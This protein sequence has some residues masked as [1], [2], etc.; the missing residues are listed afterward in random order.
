MN[1]KM[2][3]LL[4][5]WTFISTSRKRSLPTHFLLGTWVQHMR[6]LT[7]AL[8]ST[9]MYCS[10]CDFSIV[11]KWLTWKNSISATNFALNCGKV[12]RKF[13]EC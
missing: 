8:F 3:P 5:A 13:L 10:I 9:S 2:T 12:L 11:R 1:H 4:L 6:L 7:N